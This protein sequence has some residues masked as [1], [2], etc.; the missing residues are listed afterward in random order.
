M[1]K[2]EFLVVMSFAL[3]MF[4]CSNDTN[5]PAPAKDNKLSVVTATAGTNMKTYSAGGESVV[6]TG[7]DIETYNGKTHRIVF[8]DLTYDD[9]FQRAET[10]STLKF[11]L[12]D[13]FLFD[14]ILVR[15][16]I[17]V[18]YGVPVLIASRGNEY[19][20]DKFYL[21]DGIEPD[22]RLTGRLLETPA[23]NKFI[24]Y[25]TAAGKLTEA[26]DPPLTPPTPKDPD[27]IISTITTDDIQSYNLSTEEIRFTGFTVQ[28]LQDRRIAIPFSHHTDGFNMPFYLGD[29][30]M[31]KARC[32]A[33]WSSIPYHDLTFTWSEDKFYLSDGYGGGDSE[34]I[35]ETNA[36]KRKAEWTLFIQHLK[37]TGKIIP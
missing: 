25:L 23:W 30:L 33:P 4:S 6:F 14:I 17:H 11:Y 18:S 36:Q 5:V 26:A 37:N 27:K 24:Q 13:E 2:I 16:S 10:N 12:G 28:D 8:R 3:T 21:L 9:L 7:D 31:F 15:G 20:P 29:K 35:R 1:K 34:K 32:I 19:T 22:G